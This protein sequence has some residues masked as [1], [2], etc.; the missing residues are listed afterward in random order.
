MKVYDF[1]KEEIEYFELMPLVFNDGIQSI[2]ST[3]E[4]DL[5]LARMK[6]ATLRT[7]SV[8]EELF[9]LSWRPPI[10]WGTDYPL[11]CSEM[12]RSHTHDRES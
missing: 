8:Q 2:S 3:S 11:L 10:L 6:T 9:W 5:L 1:F 7:R 4:I 12:S